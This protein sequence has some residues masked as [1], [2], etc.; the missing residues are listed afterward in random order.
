MRI[1]QTLV[2]S[3]NPYLA[4]RAIFLLIKFGRFE[5]GTNKGQ[6]IS[7]FIK[8]IAIPGLGT[9]AGEIDPLVCSKQVRLA[10]DEIILKKYNFPR[11]WIQAQKDHYSFVRDK[12]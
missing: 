3:M 6:P 11:S 5:R 4:A 9:G 10:I 1:P 8:S 12:D 2:N 7:S